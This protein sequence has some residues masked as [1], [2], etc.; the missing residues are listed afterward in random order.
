MA[1]ALRGSLRKK[2][3]MQRAEDEGTTVRGVVWATGLM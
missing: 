2:D 3:T 1:A